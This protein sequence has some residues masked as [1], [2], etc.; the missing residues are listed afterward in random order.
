MLVVQ[1]SRFRLVRSGPLVLFCAET[2]I[3]LD[4]R[5]TLAAHL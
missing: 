4:L 3:S 1:N 2:A 5:G